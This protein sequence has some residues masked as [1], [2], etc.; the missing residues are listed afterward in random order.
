MP[1]LDRIHSER[2]GGLQRLFAGD[3]TAAYTGGQTAEASCAPL[4]FPFEI[5]PQ[6]IERRCCASQIPFELM[7]TPGAVSR[8]LRQRNEFLR[9]RGQPAIQVLIFC[10][11]KQFFQIV[12]GRTH[13]SS[14]PIF[15]VSGCG[16]SGS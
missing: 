5:L 11:A 3:S 16:A 4:G 9:E 2:P 12:S 1:P 14:F 6:K 10:L 8:S 7:V 13:D 15:V